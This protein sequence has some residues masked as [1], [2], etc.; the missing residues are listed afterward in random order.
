MAPEVIKGGGVSDAADMYALGVLL[1]ELDST[2]VPYD[3]ETS[4]NGAKMEN[5]L[6]AQQVVKGMLKPTP[7]A[8]CPGSIK[9]LVALCVSY[10]AAVRPTAA[11]AAY[12]LREILKNDL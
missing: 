11:A 2:Q 10:E 4:Q 5:E 12:T 1:C 7:S 9:W 8:D 6:I 3:N